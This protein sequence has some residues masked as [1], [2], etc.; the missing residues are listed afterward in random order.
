MPSDEFA[1]QGLLVA[2]NMFWDHTPDRQLM[3]LK[4]VGQQMPGAQS[5]K[6]GLGWGGDALTGQ[7]GE[8][9]AMPATSCNLLHALMCRSW[10]SQNTHLRLPR[11]WKR[12]AKRMMPLKV[13]NL[14]PAVA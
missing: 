13:I 4:Q 14:V 3:I 2:E 6:Y 8:G 5:C 1:K 7:A 10:P 12:V 9:S 11:M